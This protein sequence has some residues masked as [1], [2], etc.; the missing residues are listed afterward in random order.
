MYIY[1]GMA[2]QEME[3]IDDYSYLEELETLRDFPPVQEFYLKLDNWVKTVNSLRAGE[4]TKTNKIIFYRMRYS[5]WAYRYIINED[6]E[7]QE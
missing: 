1:Y 7:A 3:G 5:D 6:Y 4:A 2:R